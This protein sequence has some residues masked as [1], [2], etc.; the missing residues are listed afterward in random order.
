MKVLAAAA[1]FLLFYV[2]KLDLRYDLYARKF[3]LF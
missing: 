1:I 3:T 2:C